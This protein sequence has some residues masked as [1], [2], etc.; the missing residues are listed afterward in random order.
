V[1]L[2]NRSYGSGEVVWGD[3]KEGPHEAGWLALETAKALHLL[4]V[5]PR[6]SLQTSVRRTMEWYR[7][8]QDGRAVRELCARDIADFEA[9][10]APGSPA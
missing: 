9:D 10:A 7:D 3:G 2:A 4:G 6:W 5:A 8:Q 1:L